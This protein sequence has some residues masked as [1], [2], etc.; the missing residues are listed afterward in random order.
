MSDKRIIDVR[1]NRVAPTLTGTRTMPLTEWY[2]IP[3]FFAQRDTETRYQK[4]IKDHLSGP[5][6]PTWGIVH[7]V[8]LPDGS[9][10]KLDGH[11]RT[12]GWQRGTVALPPNGEVTVHIHRAKDLQAARELA[13][14]ID[15]SKSSK[16]A[17]DKVFGLYR[18]LDVHLQTN[19]LRSGG[20]TSAWKLLTG[21]APTLQTLAPMVPALQI[22]DEI[23]P[24]KTRFRTGVLAAAI[25]SAH[26]HGK[27]VQEFWSA[28][29]EIKDPQVRPGIR[30]IDPAQALAQQVHMIF[31]VRMRGESI[32]YL[33]AKTAYFLAMEGLEGKKYPALKQN[34]TVNEVLLQMEKMP[35]IP[36]VLGG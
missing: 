35:P 21:S 5:Y 19:F 2:K 15:N 30:K 7:A 3:D 29:N 4:A 18:E 8:I 31:L 22:I 25:A 27:K 6:L 20:I 10:Y 24:R 16:G 14:S 33:I 23:Q 32:E 13:D 36:S 11:T 9:L 28:Y 34:D 1:S 12:L 26:L 17:T